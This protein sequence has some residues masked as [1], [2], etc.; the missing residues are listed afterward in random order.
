[1]LKLITNNPNLSNEDVLY[2]EQE[3]S[4][5]TQEYPYPDP[6]LFSFQEISPN[7][8]AFKAQDT[9]HE[10]SCQMTLERK[11]CFTC[12][13]EEIEEEGC[14][15]PVMSCDFPHIDVR[16]LQEKVLGDA[17]LQGI[18]MFQ[19]QLRILEQLLLFCDDKDAANLTLAIHD[20]DLDYLEIY[21][22]FVISYEEVAKAREEQTE[23]VISTDIETYD[24]VLDF[25]DEVDKD[26][27]QSLWRNQKTN[28]AFREYLKSYSLRV[29]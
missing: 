15:V 21:R 12:S 16:K 26:L 19:F 24:E 29:S 20:T 13:G 11:E 10:L 5:A 8:F 27:R 14:L 22:R 23:I 18:L 28:P 1:M 7:L 9:D 4:P 25:I 2:K 6:F 17:Y 3:T